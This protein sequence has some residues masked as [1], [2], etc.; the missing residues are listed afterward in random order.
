LIS[1][2][3]L[4]EFTKYLKEKYGID[5][6]EFINLTF[7][8]P[9]GKVYLHSQA[10]NLIRVAQLLSGKWEGYPLHLMNMGPLA[11][12]KT[13]E[14]EALDF[15]FN[16][17]RGICE[18]GN[19]TPKV[20]V[21]SF[22]EK[23]ATPGYILDCNRVALI[24]ELMKMI[25]NANSGSRTEDIARAA[26]GQLNMLLEHKKRTIGSGNDNSLVTKATAKCIF[27]TNPFPGRV[28]LK[29]H[30]N[31]I[32]DTTL[33]RMLCFVQDKEEQEF[34]QSNVPFN[35][36]YTLQHIYIDR[37]EN[38]EVGMDIYRGVPTKIYSTIYDNCQNFVSALDLERVRKI[39]LTLSDFSQE[40]MKSVWKGRGLHHTILLLDGLVKFRCLFKD[41]DDTF[42][43]KD[44]DYELLEA[45][46][47][48]IINSWN[49]D[50]SPKQ[51]PP[52]W[53]GGG[54]IIV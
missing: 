38:G 41:F 40:P 25:N 32:D 17:D 43:A 35:C 31:I 51:G 53:R 10:Y 27:A 52:V 2:T 14:L 30:L 44:E 8:H 37:Q 13:K 29:D 19:S 54:T 20:L 36:G 42:T 39:F 34:V 1:K 18:A 33:S 7:L 24:D 9:D 48:R 45:L 15:K 21:P 23:P 6:Q 5:Q 49:T 28:M 16:E 11:K 3:E 46:L 4:I 22:K 50:L 47:V 26:L 12:G